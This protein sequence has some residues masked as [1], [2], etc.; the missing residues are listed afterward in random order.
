MTL[1]DLTLRPMRDDDSDAVAAI[2]REGWVAGHLGNVPPAL[3]AHRRP[4][5]FRAWVIGQVDATTVALLGG[6]VVGFVTVRGDEV[7]QMYVASAA[8]G[9]GVGDVVLQAGEQI[10]A[11]RHRTAWLAVVAGNARARR[12]YERNGW[13][14][15]GPITYAAHVDGGTFDVPCRRY[16]KHVRA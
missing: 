13:R 11:R 2:W 6:C 8:R 7:E 14:D 15:A 5:D 12:F 16:E 3:I 9:S 10:V 1:E 4:D